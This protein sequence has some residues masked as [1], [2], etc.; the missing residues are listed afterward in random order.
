MAGFNKFNKEIIKTYNQYNT[1][2]DLDDDGVIEITIDLKNNIINLCESI[3]FLNKAKYDLCLEK[4]FNIMCENL[5]KIEKE[6]PKDY[7]YFCNNMNHQY[8]M[9]QFPRDYFNDDDWL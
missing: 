3:L 1:V 5:E 8:K 7:F 6:Y 4:H 9:F 2:Y